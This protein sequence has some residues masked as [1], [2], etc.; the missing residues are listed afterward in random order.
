MTIPNNVLALR[1]QVLHPEK[2]IFYY[3]KDNSSFK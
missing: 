3:T 2:C 1:E